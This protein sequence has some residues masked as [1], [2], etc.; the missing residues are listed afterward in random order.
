MQDQVTR[1]FLRERPTSYYVMC[2]RQP[3]VPLCAARASEHNRAIRC[4]LRHVWRLEI[5]KG[6]TTHFWTSSC[7][8]KRKR[9]RFSCA[10]EEAQATLSC[11]QETRR[12]SH[13]LIERRHSYNR[14]RGGRL[15]LAY[16]VRSWFKEHTKEGGPCG[17]RVLRSLLLSI[18]RKEGKTRATSHPY[19]ARLSPNETRCVR[20]S[21]LCSWRCS[22]VVAKGGRRGTTQT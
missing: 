4:D 15:A 22:A 11:L 3:Q 16:L 14:Q 12:Q 19:F 13:A 20:H 7:I 2:S 18:L 1:S 6:C 9:C 5:R 21:L 10:L 17:A 8:E